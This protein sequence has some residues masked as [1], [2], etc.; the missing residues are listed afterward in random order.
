M[1]SLLTSLFLCA[2]KWNEK[3]WTKTKCKKHSKLQCTCNRAKFGFKV[4]ITGWRV[5]AAIGSQF[6]YLNKYFGIMVILAQPSTFSIL[7]FKCKVLNWHPRA[8]PSWWGGIWNYRT[9]LNSDLNLALQLWWGQQPGDVR[10]MAGWR[11]DTFFINIQFQY[12]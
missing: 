6:R 2:A 12:K 7:Q 4:N 9:N 3:F 5:G 11:A 8:P 10:I 1:T